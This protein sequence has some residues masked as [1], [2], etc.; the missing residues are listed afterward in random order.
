MIV[1]DCWKLIFHTLFLGNQ[2]QNTAETV[3][4]AFSALAMLFARSSVMN[5]LFSTGREA[6]R[7]QAPVNDVIAVMY[8]QAFPRIR[9]LLAVAQALPMKHQPDAMLWIAMLLY[10]MMEHSGARCPS[11][12]VPYL[13]IDVLDTESNNLGDDD[14]DEEP[15]ASTERVRVDELV[16][17]LLDAWAFPT[18]SRRS[19]LVQATSM[20]RAVFVLLSH[21]LQTFSRLRW[22]AQLANHLIAQ[23][24]FASKIS[25]NSKS[26]LDLKLELSGMLVK[27]FEWLSGVNCLALFVRAIEA[28]YLLD[29]ERDRRDLVQALMDTIAEQVLTKRNF[30]LLEGLCVLPFFRQPKGSSRLSPRSNGYEVFRALVQAFVSLPSTSPPVRGTR[31]RQVAQLI[32]LEAFRGLLMM[33]PS[34]KSLQSHRWTNEVNENLCRYMGLL[35][36]HFQFVL[37]HSTLM[38]RESLDF[39]V[40]D[41][42]PAV[43]QIPSQSARLQLLWIGVRLH[44]EYASH[45]SFEYL[46]NHLHF[47]ANQ[48]FS[49]DRDDQ[50][51]SEAAFDNGS[52]GGAGEGPSSGKHLGDI[53][54]VE[55]LMV[56][57]DCIALLAQSQPQAQSHLQETCQRMIAM[58]STSGSPPAISSQQYR[59]YVEEGKEV[60]TLISAS[61]ATDAS[62][63]SSSFVSSEIFDPNAV[64]QPRKKHNDAYEVGLSTNQLDDEHIEPL[65]V[66][67]TADP[68]AVQICHHQPLTQQ[69]DVIALEVSCCNL[70]TWSLSDLELQLRPIGGTSVV[71]C[72]DMTK[73]LKLRLLRAGETSSSGTSDSLPPFGVLKAEKR[74]QV[75][76]FTQ[77]TF[78]VQ[79]VFAHEGTSDG[80][81]DGNAAESTSSS[82][83]LAFSDRYVVHFGTLL[84]LP[85]PQFA[86]ASFFQHCWQRYAALNCP[87][88]WISG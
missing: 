31:E 68:V 4:A 55:A 75:C 64:F 69:A 65:T 38:L 47:E 53:T 12:S 77:I 42:Y 14:D 51:P 33:K 61:P 48:L 62:S 41:L 83:R 82:I 5:P 23:C 58:L 2:P 76:R 54:V 46:L 27:T 28:L 16:S 72:V 86:T 17:G 13:E 35:T 87:E 78:L 19:S 73:D 85:Q 50:E 57:G 26:Q 3:G 36:A 24:Y 70:T 49:T 25:S 88:C 29:H 63:T 74:F 43:R 80:N 8:K 79:A 81:E 40:R 39:F 21:P 60:L 18:L 52:L 59:V 67:G 84:R 44:R 22:A 6:A 71:K 30:Q 10:I 45:I 37:S 34:A 9:S 66:T 20:C 1:V 7:S 15:H 56:L 32:L 11:I